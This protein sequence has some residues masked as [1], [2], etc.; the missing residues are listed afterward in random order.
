MKPTEKG[1]G[2]EFENSF[3]NYQFILDSEFNIRW[4]SVGMAEPQELEKMTKLV[5]EIVDKKRINKQ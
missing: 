5:H 4:K 1:C 3:L 2:I